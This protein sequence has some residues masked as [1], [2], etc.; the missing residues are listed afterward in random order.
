MKNYIGIDTR[1]VIL[2]VREVILKFD[3]QCSV[4]VE[5]FPH[6]A[7]DGDTGKDTI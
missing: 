4:G 3:R 7:T 6:S 1:E 5:F 2:E